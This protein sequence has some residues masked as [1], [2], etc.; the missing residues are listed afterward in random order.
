MVSSER[1]GITDMTHPEL[2]LRDFSGRGYDKGRSRIWQGLWHLVGQPSVASRI[3]PSRAR[4]QVLR[5]FGAT[6][7]RGSRV[8]EGVR[9][10]WPWKLTVGSDS[11]IG[12]DAWV[13]N[14]EHVSIGDNTCISQQVLLCTGSHQR[15]SPTFEFDNAPI[16]VGSRVW[17][18]TRAT[19]LRGVTIGD[20]AVVPAGVVVSHD[21]PGGSIKQNSWNRST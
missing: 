15:H 4:V 3:L 10:H 2:S 6:I 7:G 12:V 8:R 20:N 5:M 13:L 1:A 17:V 19:V 14:L 9:V 21:V 18:A 16:A 11:W